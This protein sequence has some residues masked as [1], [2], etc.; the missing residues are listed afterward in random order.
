MANS[1][2]NSFRTDI[3]IG[4]IILVTFLRLSVDLQNATNNLI[5]HSMCCQLES[6]FEVLLEELRKFQNSQYTKELIW[7]CYQK[8]SNY[9]LDIS[10][11]DG[12][13]IEYNH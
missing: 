6:N 10:R 13:S 3:N 8:W 2:R 5:P 1:A 9:W 7:Y 11:T 4:A 12:G